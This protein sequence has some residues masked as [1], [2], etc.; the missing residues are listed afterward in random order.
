MR[1]NID[2]CFN[3]ITCSSF[4]LTENPLLGLH[5]PLGALLALC[6]LAQPRNFGFSGL[7]L[8]PAS[9]FIQWIAIE[10]RQLNNNTYND[11]QL[12]YI[13]RMSVAH[14]VCSHERATTNL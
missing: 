10:Y 4:G 12:T 5:G 9:L 3:F 7:H 6:D 14:K 11:I 2:N 13:L 1:I 8:F